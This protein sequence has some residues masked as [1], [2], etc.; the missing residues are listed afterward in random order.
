MGQRNALIV[1]DV[2][3]GFVTVCGVTT[4]Q[5]CETTADALRLV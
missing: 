5:C 2:Q 4:N 3:Q 1:G